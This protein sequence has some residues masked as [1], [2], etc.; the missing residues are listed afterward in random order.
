MSW[1]NI[2]MVEFTRKKYNIITENRGIIELL[3]ALNRYYSRRKVM[4]IHKNLLGI[5]REKTA[6]IKNIS[7]NELN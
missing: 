7:K 5:G 3:N 4:N 2:K 1:Y 6:K